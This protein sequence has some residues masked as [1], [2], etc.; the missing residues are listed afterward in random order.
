MSKRH[1]QGAIER[2]WKSRQPLVRLSSCVRRH[3]GVPSR[4]VRAAA[5]I[6]E[7]SRDNPRWER[8][9]IGYGGWRRERRQGAYERRWAG[10]MEAVSIAKLGGLCRSDALRAIAWLVE[11][12][13]IDVVR[14]GGRIGVTAG[15]ANSYAGGRRLGVAPAAPREDQVNAEEERRRAEDDR[16][17]REWLEGADARVRSRAGP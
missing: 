6:E 10:N 11:H 16:K 7:R 8:V 14:G 13:Y 5:A 12:E 2:A 3:L 15:A 9:Q 4:A 17:F 1:R